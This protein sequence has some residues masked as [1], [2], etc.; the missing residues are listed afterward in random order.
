MPSCL[1]EMLDNKKKIL[2]E[3]TGSLTSNF[4]IKSILQCGHKVCG[5]DI[6]DSNIGRYLCNDFIIFPKKNDDF[7][8]QKVELLINQHEIDVVIPTFDEMLEGWSKKKN[9]FLTKKKHVITSPQST[10][11]IFQDKWETFNFFTEN[12]IPTPNTSLKNKYELIK[13]R[14]GRGGKGIIFNKKKQ[15][16][17]MKGMISQEN[18]T[19]EEY[20]VD[21]LFDKDG[22]PIYI[23]PRVRLNVVDGKSVQGVVVL[24]ETINSMIKKIASKILFIGP[25]NFQL[26]KDKIGNIKFTEVNPRLGGGTSLSFA[27]TENWIPI[28]IDN[29]V[30][31]KKIKPKKIQNGLKMI[32][33]YSEI[34]V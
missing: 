12:N 3:A 5:S 4:L 21:V 28:M 16:V 11:K 8:W 18:L 24:N 20:T 17:S 6:N 27:A 26:F 9:Y 13:P 14:F 7:L 15:S 29:L 23:V 1:R 33:Y 30:F 31:K 10:I 19:G 22:L 34:Y 2:I 32:R 25:V